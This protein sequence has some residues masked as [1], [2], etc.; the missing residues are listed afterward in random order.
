MID[1]G[2]CYMLCD[3]CPIGADALAQ[4][5]EL[6][7]EFEDWQP[8]YCCCVKINEPYFFFGGYCE[9]AFT[10][11]GRAK[12]IGKRRSGRAYRRDATQKAKAR[13]LKIARNSGHIGRGCIDNTEQYVKYPKNSNLRTF[14]K[15]HSNRVVRQTKLAIYGGMY[16]KLF[17]YWW[18]IY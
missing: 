12:C 11:K 16:R 1:F 18:V 6:L 9:D 2:D 8:E 7:R 15:R 17:D 3:E 14:Y 4:R 13:E 10:T 5:Y